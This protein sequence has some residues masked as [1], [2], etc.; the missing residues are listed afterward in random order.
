MER[1]SNAKAE[2]RYKQTIVDTI[3][4]TSRSADLLLA[5]TTDSE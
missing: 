4:P 1:K 3:S 2:A 5:S